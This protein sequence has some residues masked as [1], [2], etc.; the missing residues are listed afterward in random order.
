M[1]VM[2]ATRLSPLDT[3]GSKSLIELLTQIICFY[4]APALHKLT[5]RLS[6]KGLIYV[7]R[8]QIHREFATPLD[9]LSCADAR[10]LLRRLR[11]AD[12]ALPDLSG[13]LFRLAGAD[14]G[15][16]CGLCLR[17]A[18]GAADRRFD[19]GSSRP[20]AGDLFRPRARNRRHGALRCRQRSRLADRS[21]DRAG[22]GNGNR[23]RL[24]RSSARRCR[25]GKGTDRQ[26]DR[27]AYRHG[28]G[29]G[30]HQR[31]DPIRP[32]PDASDLCAAARRLHAA[33]GGHLADRRDR[34]HAGRA[35]S[36]R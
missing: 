8:S 14:H 22:A 21:T 2:R 1:T 4:E 36:A 25:P 31:L 12:A 24:A 11:G 17:A 9:R 28:G 35:R 3:V 27:A 32:L 18:G 10:D 15:D 6:F 16:L 7:R 33:G 5:Q 13:K 20:Q 30:R 26:L 34:R 23:R 29:C 19:L